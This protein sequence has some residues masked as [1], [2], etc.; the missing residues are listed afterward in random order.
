M[1]DLKESRRRKHQ[2]NLPYSTPLQKAAGIAGGLITAAAVVTDL[3]FGNSSMKAIKCV[4][5]STIHILRSSPWSHIRIALFTDTK[6]DT[7]SVAKTY[8]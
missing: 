6:I 5:H 2:D 8:P 7:G 1:I 3:N 4:V